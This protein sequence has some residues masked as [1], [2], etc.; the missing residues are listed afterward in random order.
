MVN[1]EIEKLSGLGNDT[2]GFFNWFDRQTKLTKLFIYSI[3]VVIAYYLG[4]GVRL[5]IIHWG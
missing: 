2:K 4:Y 5:L 1:K 3:V